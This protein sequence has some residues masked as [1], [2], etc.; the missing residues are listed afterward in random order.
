MEKLNYHTKDSFGNSIN[1]VNNKVFLNLITGERREIGYVSR[2]NNWIVMR[3]SSRKHYMR[4]IGGYGFN[5]NLLRL[6]KSVSNVLLIID[7]KNKYLIPIGFIIKN[8]EYLNFKKS[9]FEL[10]IFI[11]YDDIKQF[12]KY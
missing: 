8:G 10:Q 1:I 3:R 5:S 6:A 2:E 12:A 11:R 7:K 9:G 4:K